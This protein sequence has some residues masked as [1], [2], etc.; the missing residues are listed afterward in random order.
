MALKGSGLASRCFP[1]RAYLIETK[2][3]LHLWDTGYASRFYDAVS[4]GVNRLYG[5]VTPVFFDESSS[6]VSQLAAAGVQAKDIQSVFMSHFHA[7]HLAGLKD[8]PSASLHCCAWGWAAHR[9]LSGIAGLRK[10]YLRELM[11]DDTM[12]RIAPLQAWRPQALPEE[13]HPFK[14][15]IDPL[16]TGEMFV[17]E[18]PGHAKG[19]LGAFVLEDSGWTLLAS[20]SAWAPEGYRELRGPSELSFLIQESRRDYYETLQKLHQLHKGGKVK[21]CLTHEDIPASAGGS[22]HA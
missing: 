11:P 2:N 17:V 14:R 5:W 16:G 9:P 1:S 18:L 7:D 15:G 12:E 10:A 19:H 21:I 8:F 13:L 22:T 6:L 3:G 20:D 4:K